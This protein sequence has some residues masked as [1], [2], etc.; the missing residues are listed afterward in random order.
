MLSRIVSSL[1]GIGIFLGLCFWGT[2][3]F[4]IGVTILVALGA[5]EF[6]AAYRRE[7]PLTSPLEHR[8]PPPPHRW[9]NP[10]T[11]WAGIVCPIITYGGRLEARDGTTIY[12]VALATLVGVL[13]LLVR[14]AAQTG[15]TLGRFRA[16]YGLVGLGYVGLLFTGLVL[17]RGLP[18]RVVVVPFGSAD[19]GAWVMLFVAV[20]VWATDTFAYFVGRGLGRHKLAPTL[21]PA[22]T[23]EGAL[24]GL[25]GA[26][27]M[28]ALFGYWI[29]LGI[30]N[31]IAIGA[32][33][34]VVGP[35]G[36]LFESSL[37]REVGI[38]DFGRVMPGHG[39]TLDRFD[40]LLF[41]APLAY[42]YLRLVAGL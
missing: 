2:L 25:L 33:A 1:V 12:A 29:H 8:L 18:G 39:G 6:V 32:I 24:G 40:S 5:A 17:V 41:V 16:W 42:L 36:D 3:P 38:K 7:A 27:G 30:A 11:A 34:G 10:T 13:A 35:I 28:G 19:L 15:R 21:S 14:H 37:K 31:G 4:T 26:V 22:K 20:C 9:V 23:I